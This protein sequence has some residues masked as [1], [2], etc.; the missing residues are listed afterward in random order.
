MVEDVVG[1]EIL[2]IDRGQNI[3]ILLID[4]DVGFLQS[5]Y[6]D[7]AE[8]NEGKNPTNARSCGFFSS[9]NFHTEALP[10]P[11][12]RLHSAV[13]AKDYFLAKSC[14]CGSSS[15]G[16]LLLMLLALC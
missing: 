6:Y 5:K 1:I 11:I 4:Q 13:Q 12:P 14:A 3:D 9:I 16:R 10:E 15:A 7:H 8:K 2:V